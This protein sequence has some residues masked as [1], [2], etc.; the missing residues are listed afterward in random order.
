M[1][2][3]SFS[4]FLAQIHV[5]ISSLASCFFYVL[6]RLLLLLWLALLCCDGLLVLV[7]LTPHLLAFPLRAFIIRFL[8]PPASPFIF[9]LASRPFLPACLSS[10]LLPSLL[11]F[12]PFPVFF[13]LL[14]SHLPFFSLSPSLESLYNNFLSIWFAQC[15]CFLVTTHTH[16][17]HK[18]ILFLFSLAQRHVPLA[19]TIS[20]RVYT[21]M[22]R[23]IN[24]QI[25]RFKN[26]IMCAFE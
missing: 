15:V 8:L 19:A 3:L 24:I 10:N 21:H 9:S 13:L 2:V 20:A 16:R 6:A 26:V 17:W 7:P 5:C 23:W 18:Q 11:A 22:H 4:S 25:G 12:P 1:S 14:L